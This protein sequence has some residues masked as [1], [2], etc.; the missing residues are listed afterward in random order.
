MNK[1]YSDYVPCYIKA[2]E[3]SFYIMLQTQVFPL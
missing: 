1:M 2:S 3:T